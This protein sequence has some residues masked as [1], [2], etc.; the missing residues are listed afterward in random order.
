MCARGGLSRRQMLRTTRQRAS[1]QPLPLTPTW[2][3]HRHSARASTV[4]VTELCE[5]RALFCARQEVVNNDDNV[6][7]TDREDRG[8]VHNPL[9]E[10][11]HEEPKVLMMA[12]ERV[13]AAGYQLAHREFGLCRRSCLYRRAFQ[14][15]NCPC[16]CLCSRSVVRH[17]FGCL[18]LS[19]PSTSPLSD[20]AV[21]LGS[22]ALKVTTCISRSRD[23]E[24]AVAKHSCLRRMRCGNAGELVFQSG[25]RTDRGKVTVR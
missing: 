7:N 23:E 21:P 19:S 6:K 12:H 11:A 4:P 2:N 3:E 13:P 14:S 17:D 8:P 22:G 16:P 25:A 15:S 18:S 5:H 20:V 10:E 1:D 24:L 9:A